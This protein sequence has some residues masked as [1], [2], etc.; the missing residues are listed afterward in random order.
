VVIA[1]CK[2]GAFVS[3]VCDSFQTAQRVEGRVADFMANAR[4]LV[5]ASQSVE[6]CGCW[7]Q[8]SKQVGADVP[9]ASFSCA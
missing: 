5:G 9:L 3:Q 8:N 4:F 6:N 1:S 2:V 7:G